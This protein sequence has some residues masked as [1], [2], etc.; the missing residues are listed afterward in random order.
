M[1]KLYYATAMKANAALGNMGDWQG[2]HNAAMDAPKVGV[3]TESNL[4]TASFKKKW[5]NYGK[6]LCQGMTTERHTT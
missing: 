3:S 5:A 6:E 2:R 4:S 1:S